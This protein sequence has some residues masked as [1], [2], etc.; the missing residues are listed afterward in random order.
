MAHKLRVSC[1]VLCIIIPVRCKMVSFPSLLPL[2]W[3]GKLFG[4]AISFFWLLMT[5]NLGKRLAILHI[6]SHCEVN[7]PRQGRFECSFVRE[8]SVF[9]LLIPSK[10]L[11]KTKLISSSCYG[12]Q[13]NHNGPCAFK[14][15]IYR[16]VEEMCWTILN[17]LM[18]PS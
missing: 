3:F 17:Q 6:A 11:F 8:K 18:G 2:G 15:R 13:L 4:Q 10:K 12:L 14:R 5:V 7:G 16:N 9:V 1:S